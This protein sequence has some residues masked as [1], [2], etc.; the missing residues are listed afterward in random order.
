[1]DRHTT[2]DFVAKGD[3]PD[4]WQM[5]L[6][7]EG[8]W[9]PPFDDQ[10]RRLQDRLYGCVDAALD[11]LLAEKF[12]ESRGKNIV[13]RLDCYNLP[14][15]EVIDFFDRF[16]GSVF[17]IEDYKQALENNEFVNEVSFQ[18]NFDSTQ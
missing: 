15:V 7:E 9:L 8:P 14:R 4:E 6:V 13:I 11:G 5:V 17:A 12:P 3:K 2:V 16:S 18:V 10:L 1:M